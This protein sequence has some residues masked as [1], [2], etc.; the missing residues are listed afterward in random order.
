[1]NA[2]EYEATFE[3]I[4]LPKEASL[5]PGV[6]IADVEK[7]ISSHLAGL[8]N[9]QNARQIEVLELRLNKLL[10]LIENQDE[11]LKF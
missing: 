4:D 2:D 6:Y 5:G 7:F 8:R 9:T 3:G 10:E 11:S 1:M